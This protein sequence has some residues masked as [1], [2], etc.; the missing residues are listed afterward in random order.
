MIDLLMH[1]ALLLPRTT[2]ETRLGKRPI[3]PA[4]CLSLN[5]ASYLRATGNYLVINTYSIAKCV[6]NV[7]PASAISDAR[8]KKFDR[9]AFAFYALR[10][11]TSFVY[12]ATGDW[13]NASNVRKKSPMDRLLCKKRC[14]DALAPA[15]SSSGPI[16]T[17]SLFYPS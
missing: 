16:W 8:A 2:R 5:M 13:S 6:C 17:F 11:L 15:P 7:I 3:K 1:K 12:F 9:D 14:Y 4:R 10:R